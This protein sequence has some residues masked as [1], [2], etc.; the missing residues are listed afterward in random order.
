[1]HG[2][3]IAPPEPVVDDDQPLVSEIALDKGGS[4]ASEDSQLA[5][6]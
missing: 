4:K 5:V 6:S 2:R 1:M 3:I